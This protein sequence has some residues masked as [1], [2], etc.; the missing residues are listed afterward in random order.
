MTPDK[1]FKIVSTALIVI[2]LTVLFVLV[3]FIPPVGNTLAYPAPTTPTAITSSGYLGPGESTLPTPAPIATPSISLSNIPPEIVTALTLE[4]PGRQPSYGLVYAREKEMEDLHIVSATRIYS[5]PLPDTPTLPP[6]GSPQNEAGGFVDNWQTLLYES[7]ESGFPQSGCVVSDD[8][9]DGF[10]RK[11]GADDY[12]SYFGSFGGWPARGGVDGLD[13]QYDGIPEG[14]DTWL[15]CGPFDLSDAEKFMVEFA[16]FLE[17][18]DE[19]SSF[20]FGISPDGQTFQGSQWSGLSRF[21]WVMRR[22]HIFGVA[23]DNSVWVAWQ[24]ESQ[25]VPP[26]GPTPLNQ[27]AWI[28]NLQVWSYQ[29]PTQVCG[30]FD[31]GN[32]GAVV[33]PYDAPGVPAIRRDDL[34]VL[35]GLVSAGVEW[36][37]LEWVH[38]VGTV[39]V[40]EYDRM[41]DTLCASGISVLGL[42]DHQTIERTDANDPDTAVEYRQEFAE[43]A[44]FIADHFEGRIKYWEVWNEENYGDLGST[45]P[46]RVDPIRYAPLLIDTYQAI[47]AGNPTAQVLFGGLAS[48]WDNSHTYFV[49]VYDELDG[50][51]PFD[52]FAVH[53]YTDG[54]PDQNGGGGHGVDPTVY[55]HADLPPGHDTIIDKFMETMSTN[56]DG[57]R[58]VWITEIGWNSSLGSPTAGQCLANQ[59]V[60]ETDQAVYLKPAFDILFQEVDLWGTTTPAVDKVIWYQYM[61]VGVEDVCTSSQNTNGGQIIGHPYIP[62]S[63]MTTDYR[64]G[65]ID[66]W[67]G[68]YRGDKVTP[69]MAQCEFLAYPLTCVEILEYDIFLPAVLKNQ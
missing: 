51:H 30:N 43:Y 5:G 54:R 36:V 35:D 29:T 8:S 1:V 20:F 68:L 34:R 45:Q 65:V 53:P 12:K 48:A 55:L 59:L 47:K 42:L 67:F 21:P 14:L 58:K 69:K 32:K 2:C 18:H 6:P 4:K 13:P 3:S 41:V 19:Y 25:E 27:G 17:I 22:E 64:A 60:Y 46:P 16:F 62:S 56:D 31:P 15:V 11:W 38:T 10:D 24:F 49:D 23:G 33:N 52:Y 26:G 7:F 39:R 57:S 50:T 61:D 37:R 40:R 28:D 44:A 63:Q 9:N 66:W